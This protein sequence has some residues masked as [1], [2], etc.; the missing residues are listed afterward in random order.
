[1]HC[2]R[3]VAVIAVLAGCRS[4]AVAPAA[5]PAPSRTEVL[6]A[7]TP[8]ARVARSRTGLL[9]LVTAGADGG[10]GDARPATQNAPFDPKT[11][12]ITYAGAAPHLFA[13]R[14]KNVP[15]LAPDDAAVLVSS[16]KAWRA[17]PLRGRT[18]PPHA[19][20]AWNDG[21]LLVDSQIQA[22]GW[23]T[24]SPV[25]RLVQPAGTVFTEVTA[26]GAIRHPALELDETFM[27][28]GGSSAAGTLALVGTYGARDGDLG[29]HDVVVMRRHGAGAFK[30]TVVVKAA[31]PASQSLRT[32]VREFGDAALLWPPPVHDD[33]RPVAGALAEGGDEAIWKDHASSIFRITDEAVTELKFRSPDEQDCGVRD[34]AMAG[35]H[36]YAIVACAGGA[37]RVVR[38]DAGGVTDRFELPKTPALGSCAATELSV[39]AA[40]DVRVS[41]MCT[42]P[43]KPDVRAVFRRASAPAK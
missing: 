38:A 24:S 33:G 2:V 6:T 14:R 21:A 11:E 40:D 1:M 7:P 26:T 15:C 16:G 34:A 17:H 10:G 5:V 29:S 3:A 35:D 20:V 13:F 41:A 43:G 18:G 4:K 31:G 12:T 22:C 32:R 25:E 9:E 19:F 27:A 28:W 42:A 37:G 23:A 8:S 39:Q 30:P 36:L